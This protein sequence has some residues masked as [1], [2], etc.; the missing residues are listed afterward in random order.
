MS[1]VPWMPGHAAPTYYPTE[2]GQPTPNQPGNPFGPPP[3]M[4]RPAYNPGGLLP[5]ITTQRGLERCSGVQGQQFRLVDDL[6]QEW[7][8]QSQVM[9]LRPSASQAA[10]IAPNAVPVNH[11]GA[12]GLGVYLSCL[13]CSRGLFETPTPPATIPN[14]TVT[15]WESGNNTGSDVVYQLT[16]EQDIT[17]QVQ[18]G[19]TNTL[20]GMPFGASPLSFT[21]SNAGWWFWQVNIRFT[22]PTVDPITLD[23]LIQWQTN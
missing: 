19:G 6:R 9:D 2:G 12:L 1:H 23:L 21:P 17:E 8:W 18:S 5:G 11:E 10:G 13:I 4:S 3:N 7:F 20:P 22:I 14:M 15:A 16:P